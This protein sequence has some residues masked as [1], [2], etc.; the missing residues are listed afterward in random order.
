MKKKIE[1][2][3]S[4]LAAYIRLRDSKI[5]ESEE[6][7][8]GVIADFDDDDQLVGLE[9]LDVNKRSIEQLRSIGYQFTDEDRKTIREIFGGFATAF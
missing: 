8:P 1:F 6:L 2:D 3:N 5:L 9:I 7:S 4:I